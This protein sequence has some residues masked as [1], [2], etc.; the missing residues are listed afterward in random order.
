MKKLLLLFFVALNVVS[1]KENVQLTGKTTTKT[2]A[3]ENFTSIDNSSSAQ[4]ILDAGINPGEI[5][6]VGDAALV[7]NVVLEI[8]NSQLKIKNKESISIKG[9]DSN[10]IIKMN[11][12]FLEKVII[13]GAGSLVTNDLTLKKNIEFHISG[14]GEINVNLFNNRTSI[15]V[16]GAGTINLLGES[17]EL[18]VNISGAGN[19]IAESLKNKWADVEISGAGNA[20][21]NTSEELN[22][23]ISG[24][25][26][27][28]YKKYEQLK[29]K[30]KKSGIGTIN[31]Y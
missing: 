29:I 3:V 26:N 1:C 9:S 11:N 23:K 12:P 17:E 6:I 28:D 16:A 4:I 5:E 2:L 7:D 15:F 30:K 22:V 25:G 19:V 27:L 24:V 18:K 20:K 13:S 8:L 14:A 21:I 31:P 10:V